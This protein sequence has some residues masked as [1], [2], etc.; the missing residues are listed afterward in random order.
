MQKCNGSHA[1][2]DMANQASYAACMDEKDWD[3]SEQQAETVWTCEQLRDERGVKPH[4]DIMLDLFFVPI[5]GEDA[6][7]DALEKALGA[8]GYT[9]DDF[10]CSDDEEANPD[11]VACSIGP[12]PFTPQDIW[13]HE[14]R[15]TKMALARGYRPDGWGFADPE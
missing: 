1:R 6:R 3:F 9:V 7:R 13:M 12:I 10:D 2:I 8:F 5:E 4:S 15:T 14:E 11:T